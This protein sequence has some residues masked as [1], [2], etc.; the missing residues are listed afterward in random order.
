MDRPQRHGEQGT[1]KP[2]KKTGEKLF[3]AGRAILRTE[4]Y[5]ETR[6]DVKKYSE[7]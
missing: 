4:V 5:Q 7:K 1:A 3:E 2:G 6:F